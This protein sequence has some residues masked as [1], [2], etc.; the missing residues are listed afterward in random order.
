LEKRRRSVLKVITMKITEITISGV[1][2]Q[3]IFNQPI[4]SMGLPFVLEGLQTGAYYLHER[5]WAKIAYGK[6]CEEC[7]YKD[8]HDKERKEGRKHD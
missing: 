7:H 6:E 5:I 4:V 2:L 3:I 8:F 1:V